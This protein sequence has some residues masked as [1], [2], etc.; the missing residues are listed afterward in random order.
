[1]G[2]PKQLI[3]YEGEPMVRR[4]AVAAV[5]AGATS[6]VVVLGANAEMITP[7]LSGLESVTT[8]INREWTKGLASSLAT[9]LAALFEN[10]AYD[11]VLVTL[12]DQPFVDALSLKRLIA[13]FGGDRRIVASGYNNTIGVPALFGHEHVGDLMRLTGD[14]GAGVW[15]RSRPSEVTCVPLDVGAFDIDT[16]SVAARLGSISQARG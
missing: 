4:I 15:L 14:A 10:A 9:G 11:A 3:V 5:E 16:P 6:V 2:F 13:R 1:M 8:V 12:A 7:A